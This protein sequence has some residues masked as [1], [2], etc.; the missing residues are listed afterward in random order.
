MIG[1]GS[2]LR[3]IAGGILAI[4]P[5]LVTVVTAPVLALL[6]LPAAWCLLAHKKKCFES[7]NDVDNLP[8]SSSSCSSTRRRRRQVI[9]TGGSSGIGL[10]IA[11]CAA[12]QDPDVTHI[13]L[14]A[15]NVERLQSAKEL[16][17]EAA[18]KTTT[19]QGTIN[20]SVI[21]ETRSVDVSDAT[22]VETTFAELLGPK[23]NQETTTQQPTHTH[24]FCCA[25]EP[26]PAHFRD[27]TPADYVRIT[28]TN[29]LG[30]IFTAQA[31]LKYMKAGTI[32]FCSSIC[33]QIG[34]FGYAAYSPSKFALRGYAECLH[35]E[36]CHHP[37]LHVQ[38]AYPPD[39]DT[40]GFAQENRHKPAE[41]TL[42]SEFAGLADPDVV[43]QKMWREA[44]ARPVPAFQV[45]FN[46]DG[47]LLCQLT[48]GFGPVTTLWDCVAQ[49]SLLHLAR[50]VALF[51]LAE[52]H[53]II[54]NYQNKPNDSNSNKNLESVKQD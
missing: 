25:G 12:A 13:V 41:T 49:V 18:A 8:S 44:T 51:Y 53:R 3:L 36:L 17:L 24:L 21:V 37:D 15:R 11:K 39:T 30:S 38:I 45:A 48:S 33:G 35:V 23:D 52:W 28:Q 42:I 27:N 26:H 7:G 14:V 43:G 54:R 2:L 20:S 1:G 6:S 31:C 10:A 34:V 22:A 9:V 50:W 19:K 5:L 46:W 32:T 4:P 29:Q 47:W 40:P 16:V